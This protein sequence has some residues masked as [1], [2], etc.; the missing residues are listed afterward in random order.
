MGLL[1]SKKKKTATTAEMSKLLESLT[2]GPKKRCLRNRNREYI[3]EYTTTSSHK[4]LFTTD[5][6]KAKKFD[7]DNEAVRLLQCL[8]ANG[9]MTA[10]E[11]GE[12]SFI[13]ILGTFNAED[14]A[15]NKVSKKPKPKKDKPQRC[16]I[17]LAHYLGKSCLDVVV[18]S[19][20]EPKVLSKFIELYADCGYKISTD[21]VV[22]LPSQYYLGIIPNKCSEFDDIPEEA[23]AA[24]VSFAKNNNYAF[25]EQL[26][27]F[28]FGLPNH[29]T[30]SFAIP[31]K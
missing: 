6:E 21:S 14:L 27:M 29:N 4:V 16:L 20:R 28:Y 11:A 15:E 10:Q 5:I 1:S 17:F 22:V 9:A 12:M 18:Y 19:N 3:H 31:I 2:D 26:N 30:L 25:P 8:V 13:D 24:A 23:I 7:T